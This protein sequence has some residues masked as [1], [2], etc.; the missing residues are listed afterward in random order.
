MNHIQ[1][2][3]HGEMREQI[4]TVIAAQGRRLDPITY[5]QLQVEERVAV[6]D[7]E[8]EMVKES[9]QQNV[10]HIFN[11]QSA[12]ESRLVTIESDFR[13]ELY[14]RHSR[15]SEELQALQ[16]KQFNEFRQEVLREIAKLSTPHRPLPPQ[17]SSHTSASTDI[18]TGT[19]R[20]SC[21]A[22]RSWSGS[23]YRCP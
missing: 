16:T 8:V 9:H 12:T 11:R 7:A 15:I 23:C 2:E 5:K 3:Q 19:N 22:R 17:K 13:R 6:L 14:S 18:C 10:K 4:E 20:G 21:L 1:Q